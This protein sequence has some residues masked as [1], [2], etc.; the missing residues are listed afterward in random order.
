MRLWIREPIP[1][2][3]APGRPAAIKADRGNGY[4][5]RVAAALVRGAGCQLAAA[6]AFFFSLAAM[7]S[8]ASS[9]LS[10]W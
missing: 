6:L 9:A 8:F 10:V 1:G 7:I 2:K 4:K 3:S 5:K